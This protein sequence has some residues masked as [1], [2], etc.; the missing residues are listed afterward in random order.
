MKNRTIDSLNYS[1]IVT[2]SQQVGKRKI[3]LAQ[4]HNTGGA[5]LFS[6]FADCLIGKFDAKNVP[7]KIKLLN[8]E[9]RDGAYE[10]TSVSGFIFLRAPAE[11]QKTSSGECRVRY[12][13]LVPRDMLE[14]ITSIGNLGIGLYSRG[15]TE[16]D[17]ENFVAFCSIT[18]DFNKSQTVNS[19][20]LVDWDL[21]ITNATSSIKNSK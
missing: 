7:T 6:F 4:V 5:S 14:N 13:F 8:R 12:S 17:I 3:K 10:Y 15:A 19:S 20:L 18:E 2:L 16:D 1:G 11:I 9:I 21:V